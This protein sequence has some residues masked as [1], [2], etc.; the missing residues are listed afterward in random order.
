MIGELSKEYKNGE[1]RGGDTVGHDPLQ[2]LFVAIIFSFNSDFLK[3][4]MQ[5]W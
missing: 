4:E 3:G 5:N 2:L 1:G